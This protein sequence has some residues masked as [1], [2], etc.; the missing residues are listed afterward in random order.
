M[1]SVFIVCCTIYILSTVAYVIFTLFSIYVFIHQLWH[2]CCCFHYTFCYKGIVKQQKR[3]FSDL[4][5]TRSKISS[6]WE[7]K[8]LVLNLK[9]NLV[10]PY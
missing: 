10:H 2:F 6:L 9:P 1:K 3:I 4:K 8:N 7:R 5:S